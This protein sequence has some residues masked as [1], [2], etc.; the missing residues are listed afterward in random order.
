MKWLKKTYVSAK[1]KYFSSFNNWTWK[2]DFLW[3]KKCTQ[4]KKS[5]ANSP[6]K[7]VNLAG[8]DIIARY[9]QEK[10]FLQSEKKHSLKN[11]L[12]IAHPPKKKSIV[13]LAETI[14]LQRAIRL[15]TEARG[16]HVKHKMLYIPST[17]NNNLIFWHLKWVL[18]V[19]KY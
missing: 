8:N 4:L 1:W 18:A 15:V 12:Q 3:F 11:R 17:L 5:I 9:L 7:K 16:V 14:L 10:G 19:V 2:Y 13:N 6:P